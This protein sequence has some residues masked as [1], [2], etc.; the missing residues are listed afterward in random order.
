MASIPATMRAAQYEGYGEAGDIIKIVT[1]RPVPK[2]AAG[3]LLIKIHAASIN[4]IDYKL[5]HGF[6]RLIQS[7]SAFPFVPGFDFAGVV[8]DANG[9]SKFKNG[10]EVHGMNA[11]P[12]CGTMAEYA[13]VQEILLARKPS[14][15]SFAEAATLPLAGLTSYQSLKNFAQIRPGQRVLVL[16][17]SGGTGI[18]GIQY[19]HH[20]GCHV[21][22]TCSARNVDF[23]RNFGA[24]ETI[25]Y[26]K[27][28]FAT[29]LKDNPVDVV[30]DCVGGY[31]NWVKAQLITKKGGSFVTLTGDS[32]AEMTVGRLLDIGGKMVFRKTAALFGSNPHYYLPTTKSNGVELEEFRALVEKGIIRT[33]IDK[34]FTLEEAAEMFKYSESGRTRGKTAMLVVA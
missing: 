10:D 28:D 3:S 11:F 15:L 8:V 20:V 9:S 7:K 12:S 33:H 6:L 22:T 24:D 31:D 29:V 4:P 21:I 19:A 18:F 34:T 13:S 14:N 26:T 16:G 23:V 25:D 32:A 1:D 27:D 5:S 30:Y 2:P 17:G